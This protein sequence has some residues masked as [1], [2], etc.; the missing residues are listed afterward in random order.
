[1]MRL[2]VP[3]LLLAG[4]A[5]AFPKVTMLFREPDSYEAEVTCCRDVV[6][7]RH[8]YRDV[9]RV[10]ALYLSSHVRNVHSGLSIPEHEDVRVTLLEETSAGLISLVAKGSFSGVAEPQKLLRIP[11]SYTTN[12]ASQFIFQFSFGASLTY[13]Q[14]PLSNSPV[15]PFNSTN[16][17]H[18]LGVEYEY[19]E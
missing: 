11:I 14:Y 16:N 12:T 8:Y 4:C 6:N 3:L 17:Y 2:I 19:I 7:T 9:V 15:A 13:P 1:M 18:I 5:V 10:S